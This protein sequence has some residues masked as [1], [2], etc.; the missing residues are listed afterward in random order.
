MLQFSVSLTLRVPEL[1][2]QNTDKHI[3]CLQSAAIVFCKDSL[4]EDVKLINHKHF[5][6]KTITYM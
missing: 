6:I 2:P 1:C 3:S 4:C 5:P